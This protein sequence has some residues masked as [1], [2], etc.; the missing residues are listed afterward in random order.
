M[1]HTPADPASSF[2]NPDIPL[3]G[4][5]APGQPLCDFVSY[6]KAIDHLRFAKAKLVQDQTPF[7]IVAGIRRPHLNW[8]APKGYLDLYEPIQ[9]TAMPLQLTLDRSIDP[10]AWT[11]FGSLGGVNPHNLT[12]TPE[13][14][15]SYRAHYYAAVSWADYVAGR[16]LDELDQLELTSST[17]VVMQYEYIIAFSTSL[18]KDLALKSITVAAPTT[19]GTW[20]SM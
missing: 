7:F 9:E 14:I 15:R 2:C 12:N 8:R 5:G 20:A 11:S 10:I 16:V 4:S 18:G 17:L 13:L 19:A 3:N 6:Q 1:P